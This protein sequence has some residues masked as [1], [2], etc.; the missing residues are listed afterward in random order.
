MEKLGKEFSDVYWNN[1]WELLEDDFTTCYIP[2][3]A[4]DLIFGDKDAT[5]KR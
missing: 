4:W 1:H 3:N 2:A 5:Q